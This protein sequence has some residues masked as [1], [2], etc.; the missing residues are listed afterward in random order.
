MKAA[1]KIANNQVGI[2]GEYFVAGE[3]SRRGRI[4]SLTLKNT[5]GID[6]LVADAE[7]SSYIGVQVKTNSEKRNEWMLNI[8]AETFQA[9]NLFYVFVNLCGQE[10]PEYFVVPSR[11][12]AEQVTRT[13]REW[14]NTPGRGGQAHKPTDM[15]KFRDLDGEFRDKWD[16]LQLEDSRREHVRMKGDD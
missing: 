7:A 1:N 2:A 16:S 15:R 12:V 14:L 10:P 8:K 4:A 3:L 5:K 9:P 13:H 11:V 6:V